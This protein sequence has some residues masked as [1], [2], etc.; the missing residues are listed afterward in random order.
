MLKNFQAKV[1]KAIQTEIPDQIKGQTYKI[2]QLKH[3]IQLFE[4][5]QA[6]EV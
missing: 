4:K 1:T 2:E 6:K 3:S 5:T